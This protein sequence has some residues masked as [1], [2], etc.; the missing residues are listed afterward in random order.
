MN[1][2]TKSASNKPR[3]KKTSPHT[4]KPASGASRGKQQG[5]SKPPAGFKGITVE[6]F[7]G[8]DALTIEQAKA[9]I[10]WKV[11]KES[12]KFHLKDALGACIRLENNA[13]NRPYRPGLANRYRNEMLRH[14]WFLNGESIIFDWDGKCQSGQHRLVGFILA[15]QE[16]EKYK[17]RWGKYWMGKPFVMECLFVHGI[18]PARE[19]VDSID[20]GQ[21]RT[22]GDVF[23]RQGLFGDE[24]T[25]GPLL[26]GEGKYAVELPVLGPKLRQK[27]ANITSG[28]V[29]L[30]WLRTTDKKVSDAPNFPISEAV[31]FVTMHDGILEAVAFCYKL[32]GGES[33][34]GQ[35]LT[36]ACGDKGISLAYAAGLL[37]L[38]SVSGTDWDEFV[39]KGVAA[40][41]FKMKPKARAFWEAFASGANLSEGSPILVA[42]QLIG[43][44]DAGSAVGRDEIVAIIINAFNAFAD[45]KTKVTPKEI[46]V[47][48]KY[49]EKAGKEVIAQDPRLGGIDSEG[50]NNAVQD[51]PEDNDTEREGMRV[52][53]KWA[54]GDTCWVK[55]QDGEHW[56]GAIREIIVVEKGVAGGDMAMIEDAQGDTWEERVAHL[57]LKYPG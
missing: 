7:Q 52:G 50:R 5:S 22:L 29:R 35:R 40:L 31:D 9:K 24:N 19:V 48:R 16:L 8:K 2:A 33:K 6:V 36:K 12:E 18:S 56:F 34:T 28:A 10:G 49:N 27:L 44:V 53:K 41:D 32:E 51:V 43:K 38:M 30:A 4:A 14:K 15:A 37:Y 54:E 1:K 17:E 13:T 45:G 21:P 20:R 26:Y 3:A 46:Q 55:A 42:R 23:Y 25:S 39:E 57:H 11:V 47:A